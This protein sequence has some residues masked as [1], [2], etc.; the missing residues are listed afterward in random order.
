MCDVIYCHTRRAPMLTWRNIFCCFFFCIWEYSFPLQ[1]SDRHMCATISFLLLTW[2]SFF[3]SKYRHLFLCVVAG[4]FVSVQLA[5][6]SG[7]VVLL[8]ICYWTSQW[9]GRLP[10]LPRIQKFRVQILAPL[11]ASPVMFLCCLQSMKTD[12][13]WCACSGRIRYLPPPTVQH[14]TGWFTT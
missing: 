2:C 12:V 3:N 4:I 6:L 13:R 14:Y 11:S 1:L 7:S 5:V 9:D 10:L 8:Y